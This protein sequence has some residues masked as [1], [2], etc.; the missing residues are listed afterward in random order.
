MKLSPHVLSGALRHLRLWLTAGALAALAACG[1]SVSRVE[2]FHPTR[3]VAF[4]DE[5]SVIGAGT[6][7][8]EP[9]GSKYTI[10]AIDTDGNLACSSQP[11]WIQTVA[12][13]FGLVFAECNPYN[14]TVTAQIRAA[15]DARVADVVAQY[16]S[17]IAGDTLTSTSLVTVMAGQHDVLDAY[18]AYDLGQVT[19]DQALAQVA[20]VGTT[21]GN[22]VNRIANGGDGARVLYATIPDVGLSPY[23]LAQKDTQQ[24]DID[25]QQ[26]LKDLVYKFNEAFRLAV[27]ND[28]RYVGLVLGDELLQ[29][30]AKYP[31]TYSLTS[32]TEAACDAT[33]YD[34]ATLALDST[35]Q[36]I[37]C[38][39]S[40]L[41]EGAS[42]SAV[43]YLWAD[44][45]HPSPAWQVRL[46]SSAASRAQNN[47]F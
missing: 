9:A 19:R 5:M 31:S 22:L 24:T 10:N 39:T 29:A 4:G 13:T 33:L 6:S 15:V 8:A 28:G 26:L 34:S 44:D 21:L 3:L 40:T 7:T 17:F 16:D 11:L 14:S 30:M 32:T 23:A 18:S 43:T 1:G 27:I 41:V 45:R 47:P 20:A 25:R 46:G 2:E 38:T 37:G 42:G 36:V 35:R 12:S